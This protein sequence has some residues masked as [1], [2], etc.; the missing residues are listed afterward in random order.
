[1]PVARSH[2]RATL[3]RHLDEFIFEAKRS[4]GIRSA[5]HT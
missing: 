5:V 2:E 4:G 3:A 1:M